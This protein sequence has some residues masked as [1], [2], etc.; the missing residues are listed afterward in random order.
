MR[1][2]SQRNQSERVCRSSTKAAKTVKNED[3]TIF[4]NKIDSMHNIQAQVK[5]P[6][7][8][9]KKIEGSLELPMIITRHTRKNT[10]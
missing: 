2:R 6:S 8:Q 5:N 3:S 9:F 4:Q 1:R 7:E 10:F